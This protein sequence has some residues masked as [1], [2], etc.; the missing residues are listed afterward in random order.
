MH[1]G[2]L[3]QDDVLIINGVLIGIT[4]GSN[5]FLYILNR[6]IIEILGIIFVNSYFN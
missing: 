6:Y 2:R 5:K 4:F 1:A 3:Q